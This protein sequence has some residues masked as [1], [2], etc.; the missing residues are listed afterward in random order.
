MPQLSIAQVQTAV[1]HRNLVKLFNENPTFRR[2]L[3]TSLRDAGIYYPTIV[4][5]DA[6][7][8]AFQEGKR[9]GGLE[10]LHQMQALIPDFIG[11]LMAEFGFTGEPAHRQQSAQPH[12]D[13]HEHPEPPLSAA[14]RDFAAHDGDGD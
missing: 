5:G 4:P 10:T 8:S 14:E 11:R 13:E 2:F 12:E 9:A 1:Y 6:V 3:W 7:M